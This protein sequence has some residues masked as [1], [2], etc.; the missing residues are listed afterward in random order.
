MAVSFSPSPSSVTSL[1]ELM[2]GLK[3]AS[4]FRRDAE[5]KKKAA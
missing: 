2:E 3:E 4:E 1:R 5:I